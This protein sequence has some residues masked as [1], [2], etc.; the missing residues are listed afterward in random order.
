MK[1]FEQYMKEFTHPELLT[2]VQRQSFARLYAAYAKWQGA[3]DT[4]FD[5]A[6][7]HNSAGIDYSTTLGKDLKKADDAR[8]ELEE[9]IKAINKS[10]NAIDEENNTI[11]M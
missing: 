2:E 1:S 6:L 10:H 8:E 3:Y 11:T 7:H 5:N 9:E 4:A